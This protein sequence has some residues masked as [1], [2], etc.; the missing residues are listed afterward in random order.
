MCNIYIVVRTRGWPLKYE[1]YCA[2]NQGVALPNILYW[3]ENQGVALLDI[4]Q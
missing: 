1:I 3:P 4:L 2:E